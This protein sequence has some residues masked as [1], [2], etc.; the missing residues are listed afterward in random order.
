MSF[1][2]VDDEFL[3]PRMKKEFEDAG[4]SLGYEV[5]NTKNYGVPQSRERLIIFW[6]QAAKI[7][8][9][10]LEAEQIFYDIINKTLPAS[11]SRG[12]ESPIIGAH[13]TPAKFLRV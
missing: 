6:K 11:K 8:F 5:L 2:D 1:R 10:C 13:E 9:L 7:L 12:E 3:L 4:Y